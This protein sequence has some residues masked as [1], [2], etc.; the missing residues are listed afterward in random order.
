MKYI[1][2]IFACLAALLASC[3]GQLSEAAKHR[4]SD[5]YNG[6]SV[7]EQI[8]GDNKEAMENGSAHEV[9]QGARTNQLARNQRPFIEDR[10]NLD[11]TN[12]GVALL[13]SPQEALGEFPLDRYGEV[14]WVEALR[15]NHITPRANVRGG[16]DMEIKIETVIMRK[17]RL[18]PF[19]LFPHNQHTQ[20]LDCTNC[21]PVPFEKRA[22]GHSITMNSIMRGEDCGL[23]HGKVAFSIMECERCHNV[24]HPGSPRRWW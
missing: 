4:E 10:S 16:A 21:H 3:N 19:V 9:I 1:Y 14:N 5:P 7:F 15:S 20:W 11:F 18:M 8:N 23:C 2:P 24:T 22:G 17:T 13:Q 6:L 12:P